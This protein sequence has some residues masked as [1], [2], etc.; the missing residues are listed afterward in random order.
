MTLEYGA[1][2]L[3][4]NIG[5]ELSVHS[6][7][8]S[9]RH[10]LRVTFQVVRLVLVLKLDNTIFEQPKR[11]LILHVLNLVLVGT[12]TRLWDS[13]SKV[14]T[15]QGAE[16]SSKVPTPALGTNQP[17]VQFVPGSFREIEGPG[18]EVDQ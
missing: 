8:R 12:V 5:K 13:G 1:D 2:R 4:R 18:R 11:L 15:R 10:E 7:Q 16:L 3:S 14:R 17:I 9:S 6:A